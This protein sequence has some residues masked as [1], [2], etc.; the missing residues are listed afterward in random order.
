MAD[1]SH[2]TQIRYETATI[3][4]AA[5]ET[6]LEAAEM[7]RERAGLALQREKRL[8]L[9]PTETEK[10]KSWS[11]RFWAMRSRHELSRGLKLVDVLYPKEKPDAK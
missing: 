6:L 11:A 1:E 7:E 2:V 5:A 8:H 4:H 10:K 3:E 9:D